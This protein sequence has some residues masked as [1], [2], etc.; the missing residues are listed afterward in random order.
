MLKKK[1]TGRRPAR[2]PA[3]IRLFDERFDLVDGPVVVPT[4]RQYMSEFEWA[5]YAI[6]ALHFGCVPRN[7]NYLQLT[8]DVNCYLVGDEK[9]NL[10]GL[11]DYH[12]RKI[13][14][15]TVR[16]ALDALQNNNPVG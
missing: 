5:Q 14:P 15:K 9:K 12:L 16:R 3:R 4:K 6:L 7:V 13:S 8:R 10:S 1:S 11:P 2:Q